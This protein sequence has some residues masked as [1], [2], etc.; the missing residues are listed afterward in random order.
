M[1]KLMTLYMLFEALRDGRLTMD[2]G[3]RRFDEG[4]ELWPGADYVFSKRTRPAPTV[5]ELIPGHRSLKKPPPRVND[6]HGGSS[7]EGTLF[8][9]RED[10]L[11]RA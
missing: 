6:G 1:S 9:A 4:E 7:A 10:G 3:I 2:G 5:E 11:S 8:G